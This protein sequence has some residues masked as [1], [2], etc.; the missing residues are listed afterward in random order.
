MNRCVGIDIDTNINIDINSKKLD[1]VKILI[2]ISIFKLIEKLT[3]IYYNS[4][5]VNSNFD[6]TVD[7]NINITTL[8]IVA[9]YL[10]QY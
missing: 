5:S 8:S 7:I 3:T 10:C 9:T 4:S 2:L 1:S 6:I